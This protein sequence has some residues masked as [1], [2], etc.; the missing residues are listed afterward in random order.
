MIKPP[1][2][3]L[4]NDVAKRTPH[5][6]LARYAVVLTLIVCFLLYGGGS[7]YYYSV[8]RAIVSVANRVTSLEA[9]Q[10]C[11]EFRHTSGDA[12]VCEVLR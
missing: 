3:D 9:W 6:I 7:L 2:E 4:L 1:A 8:D 12:R 11:S 5:S 10:L